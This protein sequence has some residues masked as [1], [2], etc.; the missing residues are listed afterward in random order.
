MYLARS[1]TVWR[2]GRPPRRK[3]GTGHAAGWVPRQQEPVACARKSHHAKQH[4]HG[5]AAQQAGKDGPCGKLGRGNL[6]SLFVVVHV[7]QHGFFPRLVLLPGKGRVCGGLSGIFQE[8]DQDD[9]VSYADQTE[10]GEGHAPAR[11]G[12]HGGAEPGDGH[13]HVDPAHVQARGDGARTA[14]VVVRDQGQGG[15]NVEGFA[16]AHGPAAMSREV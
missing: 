13:A 8:Q 11:P 15:G 2:R 1:S 4:P 5:A 3:G 12:S 14:P 7:D 6:N 10:Q 9:G 16:D